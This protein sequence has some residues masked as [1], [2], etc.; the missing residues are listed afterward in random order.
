MRSASF[1]LRYRG[2]VLCAGEDIRKPRLLA[3]A[4]SRA[5]T[6]WAADAHREFLR[7]A[8]VTAKISESSTCF[9]EAGPGPDW[10]ISRACG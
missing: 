1:V 5:A 9:F 3:N 8:D 6:E 10:S 4:E 2:Y 7:I